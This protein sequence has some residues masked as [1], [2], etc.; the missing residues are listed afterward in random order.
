MI[1]K[2]SEPR[3]DEGKVN[4]L[5]LAD[6]LSVTEG[7]PVLAERVEVLLEVLPF[8]TTLK[9]SAVAEN[10]K[11]GATVTFKVTVKVALV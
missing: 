6:L 11:A 4:Q 2:D 10:D 3:A 5:L 9:E 7:V 1:P 8:C